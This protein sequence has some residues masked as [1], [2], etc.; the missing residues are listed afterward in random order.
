MGFVGP[1][2]SSLK[3]P[4]CASV[5]V[6]LGMPTA[7]CEVGLSDTYP[8]LVSDLRLWMEGGAGNQSLMTLVKFNRRSGGRVAGFVEVY[9]FGANSPTKYSTLLAR[10]VS[11]AY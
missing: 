6:G 10:T 8:Q 9:G 5:S 11:P 4:H 1:Y 7:V 3:Q 2:A